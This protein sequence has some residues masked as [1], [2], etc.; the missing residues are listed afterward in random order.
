M[1]FS[2]PTISYGDRIWSDILA[3]SED[4][5]QQ[6]FV[7]AIFLGTTIPVPSHIPE[8]AVLFC[9][10]VVQLYDVNSFLVKKQTFKKLLPFA[11]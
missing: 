7:R 5:V 3:L 1:L 6:A 11:N 10:T 4:S 8:D 2:C 9:H